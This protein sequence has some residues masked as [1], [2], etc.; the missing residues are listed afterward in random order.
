MLAALAGVTLSAQLTYTVSNGVYN[1]T[2]GK[3]GNW[4]FY[5]PQGADKIWVH[6]WSSQ[7]DGDNDKGN[8]D[9]DWNNS[10]VQLEYNSVEGAFTGVIDLNTKVFTGSNSVMPAGTV[11]QRIGVVF[12]DKG[13]GSVRQSGDVD[14]EGP[15]VLSVMGVSD[16][17]SS[18]KSKI[19]SGKLFTKIK[20]NIDLTIYDL[21]GKVIKTS[22]VNSNGNSIDLNI[23]QKGLYLLKISGDNVSEVIKFSN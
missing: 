16:L 2:Y 3:S 20:G 7:S 4:S 21:S 5:D 18:A 13:S 12:K 14:L 1:L 8:F 23:S 6:V 9:D 17:N 22:R 15:T 10:T 11:V 19:A